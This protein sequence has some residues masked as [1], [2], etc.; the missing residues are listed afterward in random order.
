MSLSHPKRADGAAASTMASKCPSRSFFNQVSEVS[1]QHAD[2]DIGP[3]LEQLRLTA[4]AARADP[5]AGWQIFKPSAVAT[6]QGVSRILSY[7]HAE[8]VQPRRQLRRHIFHAVDGESMSPDKSA[9]SISL[10]KRPLPPILPAERR[11]FCRRT[12]GCAAA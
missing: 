1:A 10:T 11:G 9:S 6:D 3:R 7:G 4:K 5:R 8:Q 12:F 2:R